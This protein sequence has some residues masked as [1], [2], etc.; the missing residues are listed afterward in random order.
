MRAVAVAVDMGTH[1][2]LYCCWLVL[3][4]SCSVFAW[5]RSVIILHAK[6]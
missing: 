3:I 5:S 6:R 4:C 2:K 1:T